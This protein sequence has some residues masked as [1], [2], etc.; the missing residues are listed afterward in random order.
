MNQLKL[1]LNKS[2]TIKGTKMQQ[3]YSGPD[4]QTT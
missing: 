2:K 3:E 1:K 4:Q